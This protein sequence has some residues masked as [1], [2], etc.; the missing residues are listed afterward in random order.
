MKKIVVS[1]FCLGLLISSC[2]K[3]EPVINES[4]VEVTDEMNDE[5][6]SKIVASTE[7]EFD[8]GQVNWE[9]AR[10]DESTLEETFDDGNT[11]TFVDQGW[12]TTGKIHAYPSISDAGEFGFYFVHEDDVADFTKYIYVPVNAGLKDNYLEE[13]ALAE[14]GETSISWEDADTRISDWLNT[15]KRTNWIETSTD[16]TIVDPDT[17][18]FTYCIIP[19]A[20]FSIGTE[21]TCF[22]ALKPG[23]LFDMIIVNTVGTEYDYK[24]IVHSVPPFGVSS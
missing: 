8:E 9:A 15:T 22:I 12:S 5:S 16:E 6:S 20:D 7:E 14:S 24:D 2:S 4:A 18:V 1:L 21:H 10:T 23:S 19:A 13:D 11:F 17:G 3:D